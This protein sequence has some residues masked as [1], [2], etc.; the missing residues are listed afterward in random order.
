MKWEMGQY[1]P[2]SSIKGKKNP[3]KT[4]ILSLAFGFSIDIYE[5]GCTLNEQRF[6]VEYIIYIFKKRK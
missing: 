5:I 2:D 3:D 6:I 4:T 1:F